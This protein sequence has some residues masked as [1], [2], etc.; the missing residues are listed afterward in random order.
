MLYVLFF[1]ILLGILINIF[2]KRY[3]LYNVYYKREISKKIVEIGEEFT[4]T[5]TIE[6]RKLLPVTFLQIIEQLPSVLE[7]RFKIE[8]F[9]VKGFFYHTMTF[10]LL[11][12]QRIKRSYK[13]IC[14]TRGRYIFG[15]VS[16]LG[17]DFLGLNVISQNFFLN[18]EIIVL[19]KKIDIEKEIIP[20]GDYNG[21]ISVRRW[22]ID[23]PT[24]IIGIKEYTGQEPA[25]T[26]HWPLSLKH[27][28]LMVKNFDFT[29]ENNSMIILNVECS[30]P[31]W[32]RID[33][34]GIEN[35]IS[36]ARG[37]GEIFYERKIP[38]GFV[39][40][41]LIHGFSREE[42]IIYPSSGDLHFSI[43]MEYLGRISYN[44]NLPLENI[45]ASYLDKSSL[46]STYVIITPKVLKEYIN[47]INSL[48][49]D[50]NE[51]IVISIYPDNLEFISNRII[52]YFTK[53]EDVAFIS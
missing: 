3:I 50:L 36:I 9:I 51:I 28:E 52:K 42:N 18:Q 1:L 48:K 38:F 10:F 22:I 20:Y 17:G 14:N 31:Y 26:I 40:N 33:E 24:M 45:L 7:Y 30:K 12:F 8:R 19:P 41:A 32:L 29:Y 25:K 37:I 4:I 5:T 53:R 6:N 2:A 46:I 23:D 47:Y 43:F 21:D 15:E 11:P 27:G 49:N 44:V 39:T 35:C 16:L 34:D 13:A